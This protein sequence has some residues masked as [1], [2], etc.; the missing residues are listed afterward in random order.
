MIASPTSERGESDRHMCKEPPEDGCGHS[1]EAADPEQTATPSGASRQYLS[2]VIQF[3]PDATMVIDRQGRVVEWNLAMEKLSGVPAGEMI[4]KGNRQYAIPFY[5]ERR[6]MLIDRLLQP[7]IVAQTDEYLSIGRNGGA[8]AGEGNLAQVRGK[9]L[10]LHGTAAALRNNEGEIVGAIESFRDISR[11]KRAVRQLEFQNLL[12]ATQQEASLDGI[13]VVDEK[14]A[15]VT[16]NGRLTQ[17]MA[18]PPVFA[19]PGDAAPMLQ[20]LSGRMADPD[21]F[22]ARVRYLYLHREEKSREELQLQDGRVIDCYS[23]P[24]LAAD[25]RYCGRVWYFRDVTKNKRAEAE[26]KHSEQKFRSLFDT[27]PDAIGLTDLNGNIMMCNLQNALLHGYERPEELVGKNVCDLMAPRGR[28]AV[29]EAMQQ[30][31]ATGGGKT[32]TAEFLIQ[33]RDGSV[34]QTEA[35]G[36]LIRNARGEPCGIIGIL[37]DVTERK[38]VEQKIRGLNNELE[39]KVEERTRQLVDAQEELVCKEKL[40]VLGQMS[41][42]VGHELRNPLG[43]MSNAVYYLQMV[44]EEADEE[45][46]QHLQ[47]IKQAIGNSQRII[48]DLLD[49][50]RTSSPLPQRISVRE[51]IELS[52]AKCSL[53][54]CIEVILHLP[55]TLPALLV[56]PLQATQVFHNLFVNAVQAMPDGGSLRVVAV[57]TAGVGHFAEAQ[58]AE[59]PGAAEPALV[60]ISVQDTGEGV[61]PENLRKLFQPLYTTKPKGFGL[62]LVV[63]KNLVAANGGTIAAQSSPEKGMIFTVSLPADERGRT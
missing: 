20:F 9:E 27:S 5:G 46:K 51:L 15:I 1:A 59:A 45:V 58:E 53:P 48:G 22:L 2:D 50:A 19:E 60:E 54:D 11:Q 24:M 17:M 33:R 47:I 6:S 63:C 29:V 30:L 21:S 18:I 44:L 4:G 43:V 25:A 35:S 26:L 49:F 41:G 38:L 8:V 36:S 40:A 16:S 56:D 55:D 34:I 42:C 57:S 32:P 10:F 39:Q 13:L 7:G 62:G 52:L 3:L 28:Q 14:Q 23:A 61:T 12:L 37:R 31:I